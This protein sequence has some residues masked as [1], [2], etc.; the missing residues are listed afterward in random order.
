MRGFREIRE[1]KDDFEVKHKKEKEEEFKKIKPE[2]NI[3]YK[4][5]CDFWN[6]LFESMRES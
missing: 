4:E 1:I 6:N 5:A 3:T 2:T